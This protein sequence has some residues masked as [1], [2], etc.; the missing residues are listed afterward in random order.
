MINYG[1]RVQVDLNIFA[2]ML[3]SGFFFTLKR[4][5]KFK[6]LLLLL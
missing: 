5:D 1:L 2:E 3:I 6:L 4:S